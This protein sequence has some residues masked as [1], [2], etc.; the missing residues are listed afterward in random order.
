MWGQN[1]GQMI[2]GQLAAVP[3][4]DFGGALLL[5]AL[6]GVVAVRSLRGARP[7]TIATVLLGLALLVPLSA[8][9]VTLI[10]FTNGT[11]AD[12]NQVNANFAALAPLDGFYQSN[13][14]GTGA[15]G[16]QT[17][18]LATSFVAPRSMTC[19][20]Y[21][22]STIFAGSPSSMTGFA[23]VE[24]IMS[25]NGTISFAAAPPR[26]T[27]VPAVYKFEVTPQWGATQTRPFSITSGAT[28]SFGCR[29]YAFGNFNTATQMTCT[30]VYSC[31]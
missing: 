5:G 31:H 26:S 16:S 1:W 22:E 8:R 27:E 15:I 21:A 30:V 13:S 3:A 7:R 24:P 20:V 12:A 4:V 10:T 2:W 23:E 29:A 14:T 9:A 19:T 25:Q 17:D 11:V 28:V 6:L 18:I